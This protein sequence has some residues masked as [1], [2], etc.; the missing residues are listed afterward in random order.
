MGI[1]K[2]GEERRGEER[3]LMSSS[4]CFVF[5]IMSRMHLSM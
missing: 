1:A 3:Y 2:E 4:A 5:S